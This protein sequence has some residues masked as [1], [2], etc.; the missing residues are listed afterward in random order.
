MHGQ[1]KRKR[2]YND[3][4]PSGLSTLSI[5]EPSSPTID[6]SSGEDDEPRRLPSSFLFPAQSSV[7]STCILQGE[8]STGTSQIIN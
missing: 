8:S 6:S 7:T 3:N 1:R 2:C 5:R 4:M